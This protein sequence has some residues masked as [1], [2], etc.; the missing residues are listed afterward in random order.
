MNGSEQRRRLKRVFERA[1]ATYDAAAVLQREVGKRLRER[2]DLVAL[3]PER[4]LDAGCGTGEGAMALVRSYREA[5]IVGLDLAER[6]VRAVRGKSPGRSVHAVG[7]DI[8]ALPFADAS[9][10]LVHANL[11]MPW[12]RDPERGFGELR[13][14]L[15]PQGLFIFTTFGP[16]TLRELR[17]AWAAADTFDHVN[18]FF[19]MHDIGDALVRAGFVEPVMD[20]ERLT[21]TYTDVRDLMR[22]LKAVGAHHVI[23][24][25]APGLTGPGRLARMAE[26]Y[27]RYREHD[28]L[29][30]TYEVI[31]G[32]A[33]TPARPENAALTAQGGVALASLRAQLRKARK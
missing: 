21:L 18:Q 32:T 9:F 22:D 24:G 10:E 8:E 28:R 1:A 33:W 23:G 16:D 6:M 25:H 29:P 30:S 14:V 7:G 26:A 20:V 12:C 17:S 11:S 31:Y 4:I 13:R 15:R 2:L 19:D 5:E 27:E 3:T